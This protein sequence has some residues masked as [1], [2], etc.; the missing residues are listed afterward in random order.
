MKNLFITA[1]ITYTAVESIGIKR[2]WQP[3]IRQACLPK[4]DR[5]IA[6]I[7][8]FWYVICRTK[9]DFNLNCIYGHL[10]LA[11]TLLKRNIF[12][13][14]L[15]CFQNKLKAIKFRRLNSLFFYFLDHNLVLLFHILFSRRDFKIKIKLKWGKKL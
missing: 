6:A 9:F 2:N 8:F 3:G 15:L 1:T 4:F 14:I 7:N 10:G 11:V 12:L 13:V 5:V